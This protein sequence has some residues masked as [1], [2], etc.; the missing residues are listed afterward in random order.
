MPVAHSSLPDDPLA[1]DG[2][3]TGSDRV[4][5]V[6]D[7]PIARHFLS[8]RLSAMGLAVQAAGSGEDAVRQC[9][10]TPF[11]AVFVDLVLGP[12]EA[13]SGL[14]LCQLVKQRWPATRVVVVTGGGSSADRVKAML[15]GCDDYLT[16]P[17][18]ATALARSVKGLAFG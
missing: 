9:Q 13:L 15:A 17:I 4:L 8:Q 18:D 11:A 16:K 2:P 3:V 1:H 7:R 12:P 5:V 14:T 6:D 10:R